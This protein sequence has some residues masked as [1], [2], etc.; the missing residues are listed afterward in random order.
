[1]TI[2]FLDHLP[3][4][5]DS[6]FSCLH[7]RAAVGMSSRPSTEELMTCHTMMPSMLNYTSGMYFWEGASKKLDNLT[8]AMKQSDG[9]YFP[10]VKTILRICCTFPITSAECE[11]SMSVLRP[12]K[13]YLRSTMGQTHFTSLAL[14]YVPRFAIDH[15]QVVSEFARRQPQKILLANI[16]NEL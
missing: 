16:M 3:N 7:K 9:T 13:P 8:N 1:M 15:A 2:P 10:N 11:R 4:E 6:R 5:L 14:M 12:L